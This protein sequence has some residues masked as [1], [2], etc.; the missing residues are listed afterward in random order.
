MNIKMLL[1]VFKKICKVQLE[2]P[3]RAYRIGSNET[4]YSRVDQLKCVEDSL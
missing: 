4:N 1:K 3:L 2:D